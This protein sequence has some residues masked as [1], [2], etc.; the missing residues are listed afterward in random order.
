[1]LSAG[2]E[3]A[4]RG[5]DLL[6]SHFRVLGLSV[7]RERPSIPNPSVLETSLLPGSL[8]YP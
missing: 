2:P 6:E 3:F 4:D 5:G 7:N 8:L 1:M